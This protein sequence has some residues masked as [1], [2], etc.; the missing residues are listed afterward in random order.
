MIVANAT[1]TQVAEAIGALATLPRMDETE[2]EWR[3]QRLLE[4][5]QR[6]EFGD[7]ATLGRALGYQDG[8]F[9]SQMCAGR[10][11]ITEKTIAKAE[12]MLG[13]K[14]RG[15]FSGR[16]QPAP[17]PWPFKL[18]RPEVWDALDDYDR[19]AAEEAARAKLRELQ[20]ER[21]RAGSAGGK[22]QAQAA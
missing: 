5:S 3:R 13:G 10:R 16:P 19:A 2:L 11:P 20:D 4:L 9:V 15:W 17:T 6:P 8:A 18:I 12:A 14:L 21:R 7:L 1:G 22:P